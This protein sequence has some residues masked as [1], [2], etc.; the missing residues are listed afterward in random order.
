[1][2]SLLAGR[3]GFLSSLALLCQPMEL[4]PQ[5]GKLFLELGGCFVFSI[6]HNIQM[7]G[8]RQ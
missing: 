2:K 5:R 6:R 8:S 1:M 3:Q 4:R 7:I